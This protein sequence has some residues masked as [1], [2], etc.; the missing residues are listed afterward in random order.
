M[1]APLG[2]EIHILPITS[3]NPSIILPLLDP[4]TGQPRFKLSDYYSE[5][6]GH[7]DLE[8]NK[9]WSQAMKDIAGE[10]SDDDSLIDISGHPQSSSGE[11]V[12]DEKPRLK[13]QLAEMQC[14]EAR[15]LYV[16]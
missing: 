7:G 11:V 4:T 2:T 1:S 6:T 14:E 9:L 12:I 5:T 3:P 15:Q 13:R 16:L 8:R 10:E